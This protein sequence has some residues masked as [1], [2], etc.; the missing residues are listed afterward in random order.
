MLMI[1]VLLSVHPVVIPSQVMGLLGVVHLF[2]IVLVHRLVGPCART[3]APR[4]VLHAAVASTVLHRPRQHSDAGRS[5]LRSILIHHMLRILIITIPA[6]NTLVITG[7]IPHSRIL[8][9][10]LLQD[11]WRTA[12]LLVARQLLLLIVFLALL[13]L[14]MKQV[15]H[16]SLPIKLIQLYLY[17]AVL[18][19]AD[20]RL[21]LWV[22][23]LLFVGAA[24]LIVMAGCPLRILPGVEEDATQIESR[25]IF[26]FLL[27]L[28]IEVLNFMSR[29]SFSQLVLLMT[30][31]AI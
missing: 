7:C 29:L 31:V 6:K 24:L 10:E 19:I 22:L 3:R 4:V 27:I 13:C 17:I 1:H 18:N 2:G 14:R 21:S 25:A 15:G 8:G 30:R 23:I 28:I 5:I 12:L 9:R 16:L 11:L 26:V 20:G